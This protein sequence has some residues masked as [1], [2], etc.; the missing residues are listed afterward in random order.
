M[1][2]FLLRKM[3]YRSAADKRPRWGIVLCE[4]EG[5]SLLR[6]QSP[7]NVMP[8]VLA[9]ATEQFFTCLFFVRWDINPLCDLVNSFAG[10]SL[11]LSC[12]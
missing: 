9:I 5:L 8:S 6:V 1:K 12:W 10:W 7:D 3:F 2:V 11:V 4:W